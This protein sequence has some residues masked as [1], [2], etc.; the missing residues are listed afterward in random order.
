MF[1]GWCDT[2]DW[3][4]DAVN[5]I[6]NIFQMKKVIINSNNN[7]KYLFLLYFCSINAALKR[8]R[9]P[10]CT[11]LIILINNNNKSMQKP[12]FLKLK[13]F[14][15]ALIDSF[16]KHIL[17]I[18]KRLSIYSSADVLFI[19]HSIFPFEVSTAES[20]CKNIPAKSHQILYK[21]ENWGNMSC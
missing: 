2:E 8:K 6:E 1:E 18:L 20:S 16:I 4:N 11:I 5:E 14:Y 13:P 7:S 21:Q 10:I 9:L 17:T 19:C 3:S 15:L 12:H